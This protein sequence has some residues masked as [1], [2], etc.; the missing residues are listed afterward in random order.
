V[1]TQRQW[2]AFAIG[3]ITPALLGLFTL[4]LCLSGAEAE[5]VE[6]S[7]ALVECL[8]DTLCYVA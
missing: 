4:A 5:M 8:T 2:T 3:R 6:V 7:R 1:E